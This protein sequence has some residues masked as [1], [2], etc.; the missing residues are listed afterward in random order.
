MHKIFVG[1]PV[2]SLIRP[3]TI[4]PAVFGQVPVN[5]QCNKSAAAHI[6]R[7]PPSIFNAILTNVVI[8]LRCY[9]VAER[10]RNTPS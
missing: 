10:S 3:V 8:V 1:K 7:I 6:N 5:A 2:T 9:D 4:V